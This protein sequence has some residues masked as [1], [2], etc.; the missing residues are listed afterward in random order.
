MHSGLIRPGQETAHS[1][2]EK[3]IKQLDA[4]CSA[5]PAAD[6]RPGAVSY[7]EKD[8]ANLEQN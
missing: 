3:R 8:K 5:L 6:S 2:N 7:R 1:E 4:R